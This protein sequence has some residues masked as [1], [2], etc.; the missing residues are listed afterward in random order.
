MENTTTPNE[1]TATRNEYGDIFILGDAELL[2]DDTVT[3]GAILL[4]RDNGFGMSK[5]QTLRDVRALL[6][7]PE[8]AR[9]LDG[10]E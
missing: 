8:V 10:T 1:V 9:F 3:D 6:N 7:A 2:L 5:R 4:F